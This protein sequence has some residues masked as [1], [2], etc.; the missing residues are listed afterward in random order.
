MVNLCRLFLLKLGE[1]TIVV[2]ILCSF[3]STVFFYDWYQ[4]YLFNNHG[5]KPF[6]CQHSSEMVPGDVNILSTWLDFLM[7]SL[8]EI[9]V[10]AE[11][12]FFLKETRR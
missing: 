12:N 10:P 5:N 9:F 8:L 1:N 2:L 11:V 6:I 4:T 7:P 3:K